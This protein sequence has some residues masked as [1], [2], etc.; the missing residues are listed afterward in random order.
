MSF[1]YHYGNDLFQSGGKIVAAKGSTCDRVFA[2]DRI[3]ALALYTA[4]LIAA[5]S[6]SRKTALWVTFRSS[7]ADPGRLA[8]G[9]VQAVEDPTKTQ[10]I[11]FCQ[12]NYVTARRLDKRSVH[13][14]LWGSHLSLSPS[15]KYLGITFTSIFSW[16][17][18]LREYPD[19]VQTLRVA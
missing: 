11:L 9:L 16:D 18:E 15:V 13:L 4:A 5:S 3:F 19:I 2:G 12:P 17:V 6:S 10:A 7:T 14:H 8:G 1:V